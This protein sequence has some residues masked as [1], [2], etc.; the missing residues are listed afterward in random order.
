MTLACGVAWRQLLR[1]VARRLADAGSDNAEQEARWLVEWV[2]GSDAAA[3]HVA[4]D[5]LATKADAAS[6]WEIVD[7]RVAG[8]P[9]Q[10]VLGCWGFRGLALRVDRRVLIPRPETELLVDTALSECERLD[11]KR[12]ADLG[13]GSGAIA[14]S[15][16]T[17]RE[18]LEVWATD[19]SSAALAV[20]RLNVAQLGDAAGRVRLAEGS[21][22][23]ALPDELAGGVD[24]IVSNPP[25][26]ATA[27][28]LDLPLEVREW[29]PPVALLA[30]DRGLDHISAIV[31]EAP[32][33]LRR[34]GALLLELAP[35]Q[36]REACRLAHRAG[37]TAVSV[38]LDL[39]GRD[40]FLLARL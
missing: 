34:P 11:A 8:E 24:V 25:Y 27:E 20:A 10:Y 39:A 29:E 5:R 16:A 19:V 31:A 2:G 14:A 32:R 18:G 40:R 3:W 38:L 26:V 33:W 6:L 9:L 35:H 21:W 12:A 36:V 23:R 22:F 30:G 15:L 17:E 4:Q 13:T 1:D 7:R 37:F 28:L